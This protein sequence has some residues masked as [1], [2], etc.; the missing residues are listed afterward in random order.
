M[1]EQ[2]KEFKLDTSF[3]LLRTDGFKVSSSS[4][5][6]SQAEAETPNEEIKEEKQEKTK[7]EPP[8]EETTKE[9]TSF[10][11]DIKDDFD[12]TSVH[13]EDKKETKH[14]ITDDQFFDDFFADDE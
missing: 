1:E 12:L 11:D 6:S 13:K 4:N 9:E 10:Y 14:K 2:K 8:K 5:D 7:K 3:D